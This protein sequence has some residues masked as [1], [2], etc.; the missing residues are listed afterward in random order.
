MRRGWV[1]ASLAAILGAGL[2]QNYSYILSKLRDEETASEADIGF[3]LLL[4]NHNELIMLSPIKCVLNTDIIGGPYLRL[5]AR[6][7][8]GGVLDSFV[9]SGSHHHWCQNGRCFVVHQ[10]MG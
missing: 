4:L 6:L 7:G 10:V 5:I 1:L 3:E 2:L 9:L 8:T